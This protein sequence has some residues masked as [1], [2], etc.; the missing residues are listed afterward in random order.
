MQAAA[1]VEPARGLNDADTPLKITGEQT[2]RTADGLHKVLSEYLDR[3]GAVVVDL[4]EVQVCDAAALQLLYALRQSAVQRKQRFHI[5]AISPAI[6]DA[7]EA[8]GL[9]MEALTVSCC[10]A[11]AEADGEAAGVTE[12]M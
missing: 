10:P 4:S 5:T 6:I 9:C 11:V 1:L 12:G 7:G 2:I 8:L 3:G